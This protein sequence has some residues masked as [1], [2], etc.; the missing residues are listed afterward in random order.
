MPELEAGQVTPVVPVAETPAPTPE[1]TA[2]QEPVAPEGVEPTPEPEKM[3]P[4][5]EVNKIVA[6]ERAQERRRVERQ[7]REFARLEAERDLLKQQLGERQAVHQ[8]AGEPQAKDFQDWDTYQRALIKWEA[9]QLIQEH[10]KTQ[11]KENESQRI[12]RE[13]RERAQ[14]LRQKLSAGIKK[15]GEEFEDVAMSPEVPIDGVMAQTIEESDLSAELVYYLGTHLDEARRIYD[16]PKASLRVKELAKIE[17]KLSAPS[18]TKTPP[19]IVP[20]G[21]KTTVESGYRPDMTPKQYREWRARQIAQR[22]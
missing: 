7:A 6:K 13:E 1:P 21:T 3:L 8:P 16:L 20:N 2:G 11:E 17:A 9:K 19:P 5:S 4:Q 14:T 10:L 12:D 18:I 15:Y 22:R